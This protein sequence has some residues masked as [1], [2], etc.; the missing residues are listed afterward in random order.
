MILHVRSDS[1]ICI[2]CACCLIIPFAL[3]AAP[4][5]VRGLLCTIRYDSC[6]GGVLLR[7]NKHN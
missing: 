3:H 1:I 5:P 4:V 7:P 2:F 6:V